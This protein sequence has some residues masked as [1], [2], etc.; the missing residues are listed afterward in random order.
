MC[1][2]IDVSY[3]DDIRT[4]T[5]W[6]YSVNASGNR[7]KNGNSKPKFY[8]LCTKYRIIHLRQDNFLK[9]YE[10]I[11]NFY[12]I[13][14]FGFF[15][16]AARLN[17]WLKR[18]IRFVGVGFLL[19]FYVVINLIM[20]NFFRPDNDIVHVVTNLFRILIKVDIK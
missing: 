11:I 19:C 2:K 5:Y 1:W 17:F 14:W 9:A 8:A 16:N 10:S 4:V 20:S 7:K 3:F 13:M 15:M 6:I 18:I 12:A